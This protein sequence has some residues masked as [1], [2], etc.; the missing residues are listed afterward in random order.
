[1]VLALTVGTFSWRFAGN[2]LATWIALSLA[3]AFVSVFGDLFESR[4]KRAAGVK[5]SGTI[6]PGHGG[7]LDRID[8]FTAAAPMFALVWLLWRTP[9]GGL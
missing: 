6:F 1:L 7:V 9:P 5:D 3:T 8:A 2:E 4:A